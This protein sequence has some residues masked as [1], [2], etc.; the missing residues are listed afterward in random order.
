MGIITTGFTKFRN[1]WS[2]IITHIEVGTGTNQETAEDTD[3]QTVIAGS[4]TAI[5]SSTLT[6]QQVVKQATIPSTRAVGESISEILWKKDSP[7]VAK[8]RITMT[9]IGHTNEEDIIYE[10][11]W[12][13][14]S[15]K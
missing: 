4:E 7:E 1:L 15:K 8:S 13:F 3:L 5:D 14:R 10:T 12:F 6:S 9:A 2:A 11:R